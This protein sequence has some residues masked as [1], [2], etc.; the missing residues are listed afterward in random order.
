MPPNQCRD[1][2]PPHRAATHI[3]P[4]IA[5]STHNQK[6]P[7]A[8]APTSTVPD[9]EE[10]RANCNML[11]LTR[12][13]L[14]EGND[15]AA[16]IARFD[17]PKLGISPGES[18]NG[19]PRQHLQEGERHHGHGAAG[20]DPRSVLDFRP[21]LLHTSESEQIR[22]T[23][24][25][26]IPMVDIHRLHLPAA[27]SYLRSRP[28]SSRASP[29][30]AALPAGT[31]PLRI[32]ARPPPHRPPPW[33]HPSFTPEPEAPDHRR[34]PSQQ[35]HAEPTSR[36]A[37]EVPAG[38][39]SSRAQPSLAT[40][41]APPAPNLRSTGTPTSTAANPEGTPPA[42]EDRTSRDPAPSAAWMQDATPPAPAAAL[43][44]QP[45]QPP[46]RSKVPG[47]PPRRPHTAG[48]ARR[49]GPTR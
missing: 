4:E 25:H 30:L 23:A 29:P 43:P 18:C 28:P 21:E 36:V 19:A 22:S 14:K 10:I 34:P 20:T 7:G 1:R 17:H 42:A 6:P 44:V 39:R 37:R 2:A 47:P 49:P 27:P 5:I 24:Q 3:V 11:T 26:T 8:A 33:P 41:H 35:H 32:H 15:V 9:D 40:M 46:D 48:R 13:C 38:A 45:Q 12:R 31:S 16:V